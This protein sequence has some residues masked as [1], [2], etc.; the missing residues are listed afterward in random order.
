[1]TLTNLIDIMTENNLKFYN[2]LFRKRAEYLI[3][4][5]LRPPICLLLI[6]A[7]FLFIGPFEELLLIKITVYI[8]SKYN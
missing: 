4:P 2:L 3:D 5:F 1:M 7:S 8:I 6:A